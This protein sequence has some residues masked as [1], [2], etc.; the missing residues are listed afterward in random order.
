MDTDTSHHEDLIRIRTEDG[1]LKYLEINLYSN[2]DENGNLISRYG[3]FNDVTQYSKKS[4]TK[5]VDFLLQGFK[6]SKKLALL[7]EPLNPKHFE[8]SEGYYYFINKNPKDYV[9][10]LDVINNIVEEETKEQILRLVEGELDR[11]DETFTYNVDGDENNQK[12]CELY[13]ERFEFSK[14]NHSLGFLADITDEMN[15]QR[16]LRESNEHQIVLIKEVHHRVKNNLQILNSFLNLERRVYSNEPE[17][18]IDHMQAR[19]TSLALLHEK[20]YNTQDFKN[21][22]LNEFMQDQDNQIRD[23]ISMNDSVE[24]ESKVDEDL[25]LTIE[26]ITPLLLIID[27]LTMNALQHAFPDKTI[28][29]KKITKIITRIDEDTAQMTFKDNGVG[30]EDPKNI[31]KNLGCTII[32]SLTK[33]LDGKIELVEY[34]NGTEYKLTF[35]L[36]MVHTIHG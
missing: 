18:I 9:H 5:P 23:L 4:M 7:I 29:N 25:N 8:F 22:N 14:K 28:T 15:K 3:L 35:P 30:I 13:I 32:K 2:F 33:Q 24:F 16:E 26:V 17:V 34:R 27:E 20:T 19:L 1:T 10:S 6:N 31:S 12:I 21:I 36:K 11:I